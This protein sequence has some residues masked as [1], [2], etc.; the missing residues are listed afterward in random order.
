MAQI[1]TR[2]LILQR[3]QALLVGVQAKPG[4]A[5]LTDRQVF[6]GRILLGEEIKPLPAISIIESPRPDQAAEMLGDWD[7]WRAERWS[8]MVQ[9]LV[10]DD[11]INPTDEAYYLEAAVEE[12][13]SRITATDEITGEPVYPDAFML[14]RLVKSFE[15]GPP[16]VR[17]P[18]QLVSATGFFF[19]PIRVGIV[20]KTDDPYTVV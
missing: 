16:V 12:R 13:L 14:G 2:L 18:E 19:L 15:I 8:L 1:P 6:R 5:V 11:P 3:L 17:P 20:G 9:G 10:A 7:E 4:T